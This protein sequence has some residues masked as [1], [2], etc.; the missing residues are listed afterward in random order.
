MWQ[1]WEDDDVIHFTWFD[2]IVYVCVHL[3]IDRDRDTNIY[4]MCCRSG[5]HLN[6]RE[7]SRLCVRVCTCNLYKDFGTRTMH[8]VVGWVRT[9]KKTKKKTPPKYADWQTN[10]KKELNKKEKKT[11]LL[12]SPFEERKFAG[13][14]CGAKNHFFSFPL[15]CPSSLHYSYPPKVEITLQQWHE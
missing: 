12:L 6:E 4:V 14:W 10:E 5:I 7:C 11:P 15:S 13:T 3:C 2:L 9:K 8:G 1:F